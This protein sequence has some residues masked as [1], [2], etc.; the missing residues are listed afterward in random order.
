MLTREQE[1]LNI[2]IADP[3]ISQSEIAD[4]L[5]ITR[6]SVSVYITNLI[7]KGIIKGRGYVVNE[8]FYPVIVGAANLGPDG[9]YN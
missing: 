3:M 1:I 6:S 4:K 9:N 5:G 2:I 7:K 8:E